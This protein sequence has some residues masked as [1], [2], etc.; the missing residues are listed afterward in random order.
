MR[1]Y[2]SLL[3]LMLA[4]SACL[5]ASSAQA[6]R[7]LGLRLVPI[8]PSGSEVQG[9]NWLFVIGI[10]TY[11][12]WP[13]LK[14]AVSDAKAV[15]DVLLDRYYFDRDHLVELYDEQ[16]TRAGIIAQLRKL[17]GRV[18]PDDSLVGGCGAPGP[19]SG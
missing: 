8:S 6:E 3:L 13:R 10:D 1:C 17:A 15:R 18:G 9:D 16:A 14:S 4:Q 7:G 12:D 11:L 19:G 5:L 2:R